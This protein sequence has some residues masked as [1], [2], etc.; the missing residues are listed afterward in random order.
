MEAFDNSGLFDAA[1]HEWNNKDK[2]EKTWSNIKIFINTEYAKMNKNK[3]TVRNTRFGA[4]NLT[5][6][7]LVSGDLH[8]F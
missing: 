2:A 1:V 8:F 4:A 6:P 5:K 3:L 7:L